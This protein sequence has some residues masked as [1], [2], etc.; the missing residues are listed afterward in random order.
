MRALAQTPHW[1]ETIILEPNSEQI[2]KYKIILDARDIEYFQELVRSIIYQG[3]TMSIFK[4]IKAIKYDP[5]NTVL[6]EFALGNSKRDKWV[7]FIRRSQVKTP[8]G[9]NQWCQN[10]RYAETYVEHDK[11]AFKR[12]SDFNLI[13]SRN[14]T[15]NSMDVFIKEYPL[16]REVSYLCDLNSPNAKKI[17]YHYLKLTL[18]LKSLVE[19]TSEKKVYDSIL[20]EVAIGHHAEDINPVNMSNNPDVWCYAYIPLNYNEPKPTPAWDNFIEQFATIE[21]MVKFKKWVYG[22]FVDS[23][24]DRRVM[25]IEGDTETGKT[26]VLNAIA[27]YLK[28]FG[29]FL[30]GTIAQENYLN[31]FSLSGL[32]KVRFAIYA[33]AEESYFFKRRDIKNLTGNDTVR[34]EQKF[35]DAQTKRI[36]IKIG[37]SSNYPP[38]INPKNGFETSRLLHIK[39]DKKKSDKAKKVRT[40]SH[41]MFK[42]SLLDE[43]PA[44]LSKARLI[45]EGSCE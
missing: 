39:L 40:M 4:R 38:G 43:M 16:W 34:F 32:E 31:G 42:K 5:Y 12:N 15:T 18:R 29:D 10:E 26:T 19:V 22:L 25:W 1:T 44:F 14:R 45:Y 33:D 23:D 8:D 2:D 3:N 28:I 7:E 9:F 11:L 24:T 35:K 36:F 6:N 21:M 20:R 13:F 17:I 30:V 41:Y 37:V 27:D